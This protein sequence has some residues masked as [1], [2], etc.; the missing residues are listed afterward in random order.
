MTINER[1]WVFG[2]PEAEIDAL[3]EPH[4]GHTADEVAQ[5]LRDEGASSVQVLSP[6]F[7]STR[8]TRGALDALR[9][10]A[11]VNPKSTKQMHRA[12]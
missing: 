10:V 2:G 1:D 4:E 5:R 11:T 3:L 12:R 9:P 6:G 8:A 7:V